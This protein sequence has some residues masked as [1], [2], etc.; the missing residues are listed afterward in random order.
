M[1]IR[2]AK[3]AEVIRLGVDGNLTVSGAGTLGGSLTVGGATTLKGALIAHGTATIG[4]TLTV[5]G[6]ATH[7][8]TVTFANNTPNVVGDD[9]QFG[10]FN[11]GGTL[12]IQGL[13]GTTAI[14][15]IA[16]GAAWNSSSDQGTLS[17]D[18][19]NLILDKRI[20][21]PSLATD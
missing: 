14:S 10:D 16:K 12:G 21:I 6:A 1:S 8:A 2:N 4:Q 19:S 18:G 13:T 15:L 11:K 5:N 20:K 17:Y 7:K 9:V 3:N